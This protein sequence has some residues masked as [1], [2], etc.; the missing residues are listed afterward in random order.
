MLNHSAGRDPPPLLKKRSSNELLELLDEM[1]KK[2]KITSDNH[3]DGEAPAPTHKQRRQPRDPFENL[4]KE[5][6]RT[7]SNSVDSLLSPKKNSI[8]SILDSKSDVPSS[9]VQKPTFTYNPTK[10]VIGER[11]D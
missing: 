9:P 5:V 11:V 2:S 10:P 1:N 7:R 8:H 6:T 3:S 4:S